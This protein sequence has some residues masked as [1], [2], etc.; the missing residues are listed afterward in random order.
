MLW[1]VLF[2]ILFILVCAGLT[3]LGSRIKKLGAV[4]KLTG[5]HKSL[6]IITAATVIA[7]L[8]AVSAIL[9]KPFAAIIVLLHLILF[10]LVCDL[11]SLIIRKLTNRSV[12]A[13]Y[14]AASAATLTCIYLGIGW[15]FAHHIYQTIYTLETDKDIDSLRIVQIADSH[16][17]VTLDGKAFADIIAEIEKLSP[18]AVF[19]TGDFVDDD[20]SYNDLARACEALGELETT[21]GV[22]FTFGNHDKGYSDAKDY[23]AQQLREQLTK[24]GVKILEDESVLVS[25]SFYIIGRQDTSEKERKSIEELT[26]DLD[27]DKY[28]IVLDHQPNDYDNEEK[29][30]VD[31]V[32]SGHTH[33][34]HIFPAGFVGLAIG[35]NDK[36]YGYESRSNTDFIVT[37]GISGWAI[38]FKTGAISEYVVI[39]IE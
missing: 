24:N 37:S 19:I 39:D 9:F 30:G 2:L 10:W 4:K 25:D 33:G 22:Y 18:D 17:G 7:V 28:M 23:T 16:L 6:G 13:D 27:K 15:H 26:R 12:K 36:V 5:I 14:I 21:Y 1:G 29:S 38:P 31:L 32:L 11:L 20:S 3:Y 34:G 8:C 35:A